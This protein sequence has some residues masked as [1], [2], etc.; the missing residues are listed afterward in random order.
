VFSYCPAD[1]AVHIIST[2]VGP[3]LRRVVPMSLGG[4]MVVC[5]HPM[6]VTT[7]RTFVVVHADT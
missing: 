2:P 3:S 6:R 4:A 1:A 5:A 7:R